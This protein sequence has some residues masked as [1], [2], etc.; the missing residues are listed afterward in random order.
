MSSTDEK[1][2]FGIANAAKRWE[3][4]K[5]MVR[6][7]IE[8]GEIRSIRIGARVLVPLSEIERVEQFGLGKSRKSAR[9]AEQSA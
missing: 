9:T 4:S 3:V 6:R 2:L 1:R 7:K 8:S 5:D